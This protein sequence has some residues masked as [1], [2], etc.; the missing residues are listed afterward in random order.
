MKRQII[1]VKKFSLIIVIGLLLSCKD[2]TSPIVSTTENTNA[3]EFGEIIDLTHTFS[4]E[5]VYWVTAKEFKL[6]TV[7]FGLIAG[8]ILGI[9]KLKN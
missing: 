9:K 7:A 8:V 1:V 6:D 2:K 3:F 5:T 4:K